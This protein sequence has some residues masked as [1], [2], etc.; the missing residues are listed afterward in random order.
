MS[1]ASNK[2]AFFNY[3]IQDRFEAGIVLEGYEVKSIRQGHVT[4]QDCYARATDNAIMLMGLYIRP[5]AMAHHVV[6]NPTRD[7]KLLVHKSE[8]KKYAH[9]TATKEL[10]LVPL[11]IYFKGNKVK[12]E[13]GLG[14]P[15]KK[16]DKRASLKE[17]DVRRE[18]D[19][20]MKRF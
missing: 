8:L 14:K 16:Y 15:K 4:F 20:G 5:Y 2:K 6:I 13:L 18:I 9:K 7:R 17:K 10:V 19:R 3:E 11:S 12:V 1:I